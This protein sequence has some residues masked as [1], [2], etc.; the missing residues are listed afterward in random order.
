MKITNTRTT[1]LRGQD[2]H[3]MGG[4]PRTWHLILVRIDTDEGVYGLGEA[5]HWQRTFFG[6]REAIDYIGSRIKGQSPFDIKRIVTEHLH[7]ARPPHAPRTLPGTIVPAGPI[8]WGMSGIEMALCDLVG[9][10]SGLPVY[11]LLGG[12]YRDKVPV[13]LDR[14]GPAAVEDLN[15]WRDL[16][17]EA[18]DAGF[19]H[20]KFDI[21]H[22]APDRTRDVWSRTMPIDQM[23]RVVERLSAVREVVGWDVEIAVDCHMH[24]DVNTGIRLARE[25]APLKLKWLEDPTPVL[26]HEAVAAIRAR[27]DIPI[28][29]GEMFTP[30]EARRFIDAEACDIIHPDVLFAGGLHETRKIAEYAELHQVPV[31]FHNNSTALGVTA[32]AHVAATVGNLVGIEY[33]FHDAPWSTQIVERGRP[34]I[35]DGY[36]HLT[37]RPG[38]GCELN[39]SVCRDLLAEGE[40]LF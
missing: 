33:H 8:V 27:S 26:N 29:V 12:A 9:K 34:L 15:A 4:Q 36:L 20:L 3:G 32:S 21:D 24:Y 37:D 39:E 25:L 2:P 18:R 30:E 22:V 13:Y 7:G 14:S 23:N 5:P 38:L 19:D 31:A 6:V 35:E 11:N 17:L 40:T 10:A 16:A 28:C 1:V